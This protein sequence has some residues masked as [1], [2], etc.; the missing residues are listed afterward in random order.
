[1]VCREGGELGQ[2]GEVLPV[3]DNGRAEHGDDRERVDEE[4]ARSTMKT[5]AVAAK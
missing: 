2:L 5:T 1:M 3:A 4:E